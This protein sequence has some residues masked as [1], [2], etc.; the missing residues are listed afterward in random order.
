MEVV[1]FQTR[2][3]S[4]KGEVHLGKRPYRQSQ[5]ETFIES[6]MPLLITEFYKTWLT[7]LLTF[8]VCSRVQMMGRDTLDCSI[9]MAAFVWKF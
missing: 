5:V 1:G 4:S 6:A 2:R 9:T 8:F 3:T 7:H